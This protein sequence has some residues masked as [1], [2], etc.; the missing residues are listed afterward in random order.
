MTLNPSNFQRAICYIDTSSKGRGTLTGNQSQSR[1]SITWYKWT[2]ERLYINDGPR[3]QNDK[4]CPEGGGGTESKKNGEWEGWV[5][6]K[7][8]ERTHHDNKIKINPREETLGREGC[9]G[10]VGGVR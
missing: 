9:V 8:D 1:F 3:D 10:E 2:N 4:K 6:K 5:G 7:S